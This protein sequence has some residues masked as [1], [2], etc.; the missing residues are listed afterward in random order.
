MSSTLSTSAVVGGTTKLLSGLFP[1]PSSFLESVGK[2]S[3]GVAVVGTGAGCVGLGG[4]GDGMCSSG[5]QRSI[6]RMV[7]VRSSLNSNSD[8]SAC[9]VQEYVMAKGHIHCERLAYD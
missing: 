3:N 8:P 4:E 2:R 1:A 7:R 6:R 5:R 9:N